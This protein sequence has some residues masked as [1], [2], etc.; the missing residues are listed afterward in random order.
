MPIVDAANAT[1]RGANAP[2]A[3]RSPIMISVSAAAG[4]AARQIFAEGRADSVLQMK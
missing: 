2:P 1:E 4:V 3:S